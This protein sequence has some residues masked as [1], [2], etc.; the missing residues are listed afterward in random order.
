M[1]LR[2]C[3][4]HYLKEKGPLHDAFMQSEQNTAAE[5]DRQ[6]EQSE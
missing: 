3:S 4:L 1:Q 6:T 5:A 2:L